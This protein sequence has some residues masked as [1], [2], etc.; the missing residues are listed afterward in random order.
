MIFN[1]HNREGPTHAGGPALATPR[2]FTPRRYDAARF[3]CARCAAPPCRSAPMAIRIPGLVVMRARGAHQGPGA[4]VEISG[5]FGD[6]AP[7]RSGTI[8][9]FQRLICPNPVVMSH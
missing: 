5:D 1:C 9:T 7:G 4:A 8:E 6:G 3:H 2:R